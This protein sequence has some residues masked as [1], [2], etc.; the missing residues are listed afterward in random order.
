VADYA[1]VIAQDVDGD[2]LFVA[3]LSDKGVTRTVQNTIDQTRSHSKIDF[4]N[5]TVERL[6]QAGHGRKIVDDVYD[7]AA[8]LL[9]FE[10]LGGAQA[11]LDM[12]C[13]FANE[14]FAFGRPIGSFQGIKHRL[15]EMYVS[16]ELARSNCYH[17][18]YALSR[19]TDDLPVAAAA[20]RIAAGQ[21]FYECARE[22]TQVHGGMGFAWQADCHLYYRRAKLLSLALGGEQLWKDKLIHRLGMQREAHVG[23]LSAV[24]QV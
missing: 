1:I 10:Q 19:N 23:T 13:K 4:R 14:R 8:V 24:N 9:A 7:R 5:V 22:N 17:G 15:A 2:S 11:A 12:G 16:L 21:A 18:A 20:S 6:G 3:M